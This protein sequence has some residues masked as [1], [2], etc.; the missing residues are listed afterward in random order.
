MSKT[1]MIQ[2]RNVPDDLHR[3]LKAKAAQ[4]GKS[5]SDYL[6]DELRPLAERLTLAELRARIAA[7]GPVDL[8]DGLIAELIRADRDERDRTFEP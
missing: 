7:R 4:A 2:I 8:P 3:R 5:L 6:L 1:K